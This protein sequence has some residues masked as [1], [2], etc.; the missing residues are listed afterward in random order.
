M[1]KNYSLVL[2]AFLCFVVSGFGQVAAWDFTGEAS[3]ATSTADVYSANL[4]SSNL[5]TRGTT[6]ASSAGANSFRTTGFQNNG[7]SGTISILSEYIRYNLIEKWRFI[8]F[9]INLN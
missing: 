8:F 4:D 2:I 3:P 5:I 7:I 9:E 1:I 6:A